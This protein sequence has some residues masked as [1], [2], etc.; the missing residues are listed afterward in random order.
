MYTRRG[1]RGF[2]FVCTFDFENK[3]KTDAPG[4]S[5]NDEI[6]PSHTHTTTSPRT[7]D[8]ENVAEG[9][10]VAQNGGLII[11]IMARDT[12]AGI[13]AFISNVDALAPFFGGKLSVVIYENDSV[14][15]T[16]DLI[17]EWRDKVRNGRWGERFRGG[18]FKLSK[19]R[20]EERGGSRR[21]RGAAQKKKKKL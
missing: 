19:V 16:R 5:T 3:F 7:A 14:D 2:P 15:G 13:P 4:K 8:V 21:R 17:K 9:V 6:L 18:S 1:P 12:A 20:V 10:N 11:N